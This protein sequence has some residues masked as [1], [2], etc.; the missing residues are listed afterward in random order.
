MLVLKCLIRSHYKVVVS[1]IEKT[2]V[3]IVFIH[4]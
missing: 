2:Q 4:F 3:N 1:T